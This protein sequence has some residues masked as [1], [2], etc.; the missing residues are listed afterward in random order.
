MGRALPKHFGCPS[1]FTLELLGG[2]WKTI[3]L[4][5]LKE[6][7]LRYGEL[8]K[9]MPRLSDKVLTERLRELELSG[10]VTRSASS[11]RVT[12]Y[13]LTERGEA[14]RLWVCYPRSHGTER[15]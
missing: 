9:F 13:R 5:F 4:C 2:K 6:G 10:L 3:I 15:L 12:T 14:L 11:S 7:A 8:R 1:E